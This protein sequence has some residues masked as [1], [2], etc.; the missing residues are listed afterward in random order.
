MT[1]SPNPS[2]LITGARVYT[3]DPANPWAEAVVTQGNTI[4]FVGSEADARNGAPAGAEEIRLNGG[5]VVP[6]LN[7]AHVHMNFGSY[8]L[9]ILSFEGVFDLGELQARLREYAAANPDRTWIEGWGLPYEALLE[10]ER[11]REAL[12]E[13]VADRPVYIKAFDGH[14]AWCNTAG[15]RAAGIERGAD[16]PLPNEVVV[17]PATGLATGMLKEDLA[18]VIVDRAIGAPTD[19]DLDNQLC[20]GMRHLNRLGVTSAADMMSARYRLEQVERLLQRGDVTVRHHHYIH[21]REEMPRDYI[22]EALALTKEFTGPWNHTNGIKMFI[23]GVVEAKTAWM[24]T[25]YADGTDDVGVPD[26]TPDYYR[27]V[28]IEAHRLG[29]D[30]ATHAIGEQGVRWAVQSYI[31]A[32]EAAGGRHG[33]RHR[34]EHIETSHPEDLPLFGR[35]G[36]TASMQPLHAAPTTDPRDTP[37]TRNVGP[38]REINAFPWRRLLETGARLAFGSDWPIVTADVRTG[39]H[40][41]VTRRNQQGEPA[42]GWQP[43]L[44]VTLSQ[45]LDAYTTGAA[46]AEGQDDVKGML[47]PGMLA[48]IAAFGEDL[49]AIEPAAILN[50]PVTLTVVDGRVV[51]QEL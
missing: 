37:W 11:P 8:N 42:D 45:A 44:S 13:A 1:T 38:A 15:L 51:H 21:I 50:V 34:V 39:L 27:E 47:R 20:I 25:P 36:I 29:M 49:F 35:Y 5:L 18:K 7:D 10:L 16:V 2:L 17:D 4:A 19:E 6:G 3:A 22:Q 23:D 48:D 9:T 40:T 32:Q 12:D 26:M 30:V 24:T 31:A 28:C 41:A 43:Q 33:R 14:S 46:Y